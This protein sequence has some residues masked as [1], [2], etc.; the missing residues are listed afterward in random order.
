MGIHEKKKAADRQAAC[1]SYP[2]GGHY[3]D[4]GDYGH[5]GYDHGEYGHRGAVIVGPPVLVVQ[6]PVVIVR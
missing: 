1:G 3:Y 5:D 2:T 6:P 4:H